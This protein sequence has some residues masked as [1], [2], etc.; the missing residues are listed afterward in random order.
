MKE[1][2][3]PRRPRSAPPLPPRGPLPVTAATVLPTVAVPLLAAFGAAA[4]EITRDVVT[5]DRMPGLVEEGVDVA[6][7]FNPEPESSLIV[8]HLGS[9]RIICVAAPSYLARHGTPRELADL[10]RHNF[11]SYIYP[12]F[13][14]LTRE[15][16]LRGPGVE[17]T[18]PISGKLHSQTTDPIPT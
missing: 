14:T 16:R 1:L 17:A 6:L 12:R 5:T 4:P 7:R 18:A 10:A 15:S 13:T 9:F 3:Q 11:L 2:D 8:R